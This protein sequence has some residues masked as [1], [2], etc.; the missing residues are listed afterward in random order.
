MKQQSTTVFLSSK[1]ATI[2]ASIPLSVATI[3]IDIIE[4]RLVMNSS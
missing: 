3:P 1:Q 4:R 2:L